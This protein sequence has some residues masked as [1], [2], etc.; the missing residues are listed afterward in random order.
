MPSLINTNS[1]PSSNLTWAQAKRRV[2]RS[3]GRMNDPNI[4]D[5]AQDAISE[6]IQDWNTEKDWRFLQIIAPDITTTAGT[7]RYP[8]P[9]NYKKPYDAYLRVAQR[10]LE[11]VE[12]RL[13]DTLFPGGS[14]IT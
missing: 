9:T 13:H 2:A 14:T 12:A 5:A 11:Y 6:A 8:L 3:V 1:G 4:L 7:N 10:K